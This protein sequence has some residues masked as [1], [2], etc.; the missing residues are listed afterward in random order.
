MANLKL[1]REYVAVLDDLEKWRKVVTNNLAHYGCNNITYFKTKEGIITRYDPNT[2]IALL[3][4]NLNIDDEN[5]KEGLEVCQFFKKTA[6]ETT[7]VV[8]SSLENMANEAKKNGA[9]FIIQK[10]NF[11]QDFDTFV[12]K[13]TSKS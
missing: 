12:K 11:M 4:I 1:A 5:N 7:I 8:M 3:D 9:D 6:P 2:T 10:K 13:Y